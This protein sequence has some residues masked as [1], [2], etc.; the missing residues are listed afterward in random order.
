M[1]LDSVLADIAACRACAGELPHTPRPVLANYGLDTLRFVKPVLIGDT[2]QAR[3][4]CKR[5]I[6]K[7]KRDAKGQGQGVD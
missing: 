6:D 4:T 5:K 1:S 2:I 3:L 7:N